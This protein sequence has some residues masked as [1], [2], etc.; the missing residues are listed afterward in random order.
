MHSTQDCQL[1]AEGGDAD[2]GSVD[3]RGARGVTLREVHAGSAKGRLWR[4][5]RGAGRNVD[6]SV[7]LLARVE[8]REVEEWTV[9]WL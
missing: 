3:S 2:G 8:G 9:M 4:E 5:A 1:L 6:W 7:L